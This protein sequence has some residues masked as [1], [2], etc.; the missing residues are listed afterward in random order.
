MLVALAVLFLTSCVAPDGYVSE[1]GTEAE[2]AT[3]TTAAQSC[4]PESQ[5]EYIA[6]TTLVEATTLV[7]TT[8]IVETMTDATVVEIED[9]S[10]YIQYYTKQDAIDIAKVLYAEC[11]GVPSTTEQACVAWTILNSVDKYES[12]VYSVVRAPNQYAFRSGSPVNDDLLDL[13]YDVLDRWNREKNGETG[14]G[15][16]LPPEYTFFEGDGS[17]NHF[18]DNYNGSYNIWDYSLESPYES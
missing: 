2:A 12:T 8:A 3:G 13:A 15:R 9:E 11:R 10:I 14:V 7:E 5:H 6:E 4:V 17:H 18:R 16:V 1:V